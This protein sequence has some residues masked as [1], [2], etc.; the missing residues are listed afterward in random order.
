VFVASR[1]HLNIPART[2]AIRRM[3]EIAITDITFAHIV[4]RDGGREFQN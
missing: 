2:E 3:V 4:A 1:R